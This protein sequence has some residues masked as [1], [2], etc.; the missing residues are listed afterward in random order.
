MPATQDAPTT[1]PIGRD[2]PRVDGPLKVS[3]TAQYTS[4]F[5]FP[6]HALRRAGRGDDRQWPR[7]RSSTRPPPRRCPACARSSTAR[8]SARSSARSLGPG[9]EGISD[10]RRPP[11]EDDVDPLLRP[12]RRAR[13][14]GHV[15]DGEGRGRC[16]ARH[17]R[18]GEAERRHRPQGGR[19]AGRGRHD[20]R[21]AQA[22]QSERGDADERVRDARRSSSTRP[23]SRRPRRT[24]PIELHATTAVWDGTTLTLYESSQGVVN[25]QDVLAQMFGLPKENV[26][27][28][29]KFLGSGFGGKLWPWTHCPLAAA[30]ARQLGKPV[31]LVVSRKMMFQTVGH[32]PRTQ[33]RVRLGA[34]PDG[35]LVSLQHDYVNTTSMLDDYHE[36]CGEATPF[37][38]QRAES[39]RDVRPRQA[40]RRLADR[41]A[42]PGRGARPLRDRVGD[43]RAGRS[44]QDRPGPAPPPQRAE[45]RRGAGHAVLVA[46]SARVPA[47]SAR[48][49][50]AGRSAR[51]RSAR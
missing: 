27:V 44:A 12:V 51:R 9:F 3:G 15:R 11:F 4:D 40:Q 25:L 21:H 30:A 43:E 45:D 32:R 39:A 2:T 23:T 22:L 20:V 19:R 18:H 13:R 1:S 31:K 46:P 24:I 49:S 17:V 5:H 35:K 50:S 29:T 38:V 26:R 48:R 10:E 8:T 41:H 36:D 28:I 7:R 14:G 33:Q 6:G 42:R 47:S 37:H 34:T 16:G